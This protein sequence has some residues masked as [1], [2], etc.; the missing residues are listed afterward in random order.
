MSRA[1][2]LLD[3]LTD[4]RIAT[5]GINHSEEPHIV[6][7]SDKTITVPNELKHI[8]V[9]GEHNIETVTFDCPRYWDGHDL[10]QMQM[11]IVYQR[12][13]RYREPHPVENLRVDDVDDNT[14]HFEWTVSGNV[15]AVKGTISF[16]VCAKLSDY[17]GNREREWHTRLNQDLIVDEGM[18]CTGEEIIT[19]NP[20]I[21]EY[22][23]SQLDDLKNSGGVSDEQVANAVAAYLEENP[24]DVGVGEEEVRSIIV[25]YLQE[26]PPE[27][28]MI[29]EEQIA[30]AV[31]NYM[32]QHP[33]EGEDGGH[34]IPVVTQSTDNTMQVSFTPS[35]ADM[36]AVD[37]V[38]VNLPVGEGSGQNAA[39]PDWSRLK[40]CV[41]GDSQT[42][43]D[44]EFAAT[45]YYDIIHNKTG[46]NLE[47]DGVGGTGYAAGY[48]TET[49]FEDR[50]K[51]I[52]EDVDIVTIWGS[53]ND[54]RYAPDRYDLAIYNT[55]SWIRL[56]R[57]ALRVIV[58]PPAPIS[59]Y[60]RRSAEWE[61]YCDR[62]ELCARVCGCRYVR[63]LYDYPPFDPAK[64]LLGPFFST[65]P[66]GVHINDDGHRAIAP[67]FYNALLQELE[68]EHGYPSG[69]TGQNQTQEVTTTVSVGSDPVTLDGTA[70]EQVVN[71]AW[72]V[73]NARTVPAFT[74][75]YVP[76]DSH[77]MPKEFATTVYTNLFGGMYGN[78][79]AF[80]QGHQYFQA[81]KYRMD[82]DSTA[83][84]HSVSAYPAAK[85]S[86]TGWIYA[87]ATPP[88]VSAANFAIRNTNTGTGVIDYLYCIDITAMQ[89]AGLVAED[90]TLA[91]LAEVFG[92]LPL[93]PGQDYPGGTI[94]NGTA[95]LSIDRGG[96]ISTVDNSNATATVKGGDT[97]SVEGGSVTFL[98]K[99][100]KTVSSSETGAWEG[101]KWVAFG[102]SLTDGSINADTKYHKLIAESTGIKVVDMGVGGTGY[103]RT[104]ESGTAFYQRMATVPA[105]A[106]IITIFGSVNDWRTRTSSVEI[107]AAT[108]TIESG[109]LAGY[110][111]KCIDVAI[112]KAP[113]AQIALITPMDYHGIPD[114]TME[115]IANIIMA[116]AKYHK[117]KCLDLYHESGFR[118]D[119]PIYAQVYCTDY[120]ET[121]DTYGHPSN[122]AHERI[123]APEFMELLRRMISGQD[124]KPCDITDEQIQEIA[125]VAA[126]MVEVPDDDHINSLINTALGVIENG[127]Y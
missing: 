6:I 120:S 116:V 112:E 46:I 108:D 45:R 83:E 3:S 2:E 47:I 8:A 13:D 82:D 12:P 79:S 115:D 56:A 71:L 101:V 60:D 95:T 77:P 99:V 84:L 36:P 124:S 91:E 94:G 103:W 88:G 80:V 38:T 14:I 63:D 104:N 76:N 40:W 113:Y 61:A 20:D 24:I 49:S 54:I 65:D 102:D 53:A 25:A 62:L 28:G 30:S 87:L 52:P 31:A 18:D 89:E 19:Q 96:Q 67:F 16:M 68:L 39:Y 43:Q 126:G 50:I 57:P 66:E 107:G 125:E 41:I 4:D 127:S 7:E 123:I 70:P 59:W 37:P 75:Y 72:T 26:N 29:T 78:Q 58:V 121:A 42:A 117:I 35:K 74:N 27:V 73:E 119:D 44:N 110:I 22:I 5:Y 69:G 15:T 33:V 34:Y 114:D 106:D 85:M 17:D 86:G 9:Q 1:E 109:T 118:V 51:A 11:R 97:L 23:L 64:E 21:L 48:S 93:V 105:D 111:N 90:I 32:S 92:E 100:L 81:L 10:S 122:L 55:L 98:L